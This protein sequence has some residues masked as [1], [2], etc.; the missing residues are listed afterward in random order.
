MCAA[1]FATD[2][3]NQPDQGKVAYVVEGLH[4]GFHVGFS[5][6]AKL[7]LA[8][9]NKPSALI[10]AKVVDKYLAKEVSCGRV[11]SWPLS[12]SSP[13]APVHQ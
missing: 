12:F 7:K 1:N 2:L 6:N 4:Q 10:L 11:R 9:W 5:H 13:A 8:K 3:T